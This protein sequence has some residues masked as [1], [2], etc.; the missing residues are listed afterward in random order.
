MWRLQSSYQDAMLKFDANI[1]HNFQGN[2]YY[3]YN[4]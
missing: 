3:L 2:Y 4:Y 1:F